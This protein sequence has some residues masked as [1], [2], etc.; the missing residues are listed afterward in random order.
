MHDPASPQIL[1][2]VA[3][4][5]LGLFFCCCA[6][7]IWP[8][9]FSM[10]VAAAGACFILYDSKT[11][12]ELTPQPYGNIVLA[13][14]TGITLFLATYIG[15]EGAQV[16][17][18]SCLG[19]A[20]AHTTDVM[21]LSLQAKVPF[22]SFAWS[23]TCAALG[24]IIFHDLCRQTVLATLAPLIGGLLVVSGAGTVAAQSGALPALSPNEVWID[25]LC[26]LF[27]DVGPL[28]FV[29]ECFF[30]VLSSALYACKKQQ[31]EKY[32]PTMYPQAGLSICPMV[33]GLVIGA[34]VTLTG[35]S[36]RPLSCTATS[37]KQCPP[38]RTPVKNHAWPAMAGLAW[39]VISSSGS[40]IQ[41]YNLPSAQDK[42]KGSKGGSSYNAVRT[43]DEH[44]RRAL[45]NNNQSNANRY[46]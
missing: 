31:H 24:V 17:F 20:T 39:V 21:L 35:L 8:V 13:T 46:R 22:A 5:V 33:F 9:F 6:S 29:A 16:I 26:S 37:G 10:L 11:V 12:P 1:I 23:C 38:W 44:E 18:G 41:L 42:L 45:V 3:A 15:F 19:L 36:S 34:V 32:G 27:G 14:Q 43:S 7:M 40:M 25:A 30:C 4:I 28:L 2:A